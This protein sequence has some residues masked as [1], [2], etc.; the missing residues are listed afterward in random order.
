MARP[1][2]IPELYT[3]EK[4]WDEWIDHFDSVAQ[5]CGWDG[6]N[7]LKW[8]RVRLT[9][10]AGT[11]FRRLPEETRADFDRATEALRRQ[12]EPESKKELYRA[13]LQ[14]RKKKRNEEWAIFGE[15]LKNLA[16][17][18]YPA[19]PLEARERFALNQY[20]SQLDNPQVAFSVKQTKPKTVDD[21]VTYVQHFRSYLLG[22]EFQLRTDHGSLTWLANF[23]EPEG[24]L[25]RWLEQLQEFHF[26]IVHRPGK[27]HLNADALS[28]RPCTQCGRDSHGEDLTEPAPKP[29]AVLLERPPQDLRKLQLEYGPCH[30]LLQAV[31]KGKKP[32]VGDVR[33]EGPEAQRLLQL[34]E[35]L[36]VDQGLLKR[37]YEDA[38]GNSSWQQLVV[39]RTLREEIMQELHAGPLEGHLGVD[40]TVAKIKE[41]FYWPGMYRD[42]EQWIRTC[43]SCATRKSA[44]QQN[45]GPLQTIKTGYRISSIRRRGYY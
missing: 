30:L 6:A 2:V 37:K 9:E 18:A 21:A 22:R 5:V 35:R 11:F 31:E 38:R 25:A 32:D 39:P 26:Q 42:V 15:D 20:L 44:P 4:S 8:L 28:R 23:R 14:A 41:R 13:E 40:K 16:D 17:K 43:A 34:W 24:Q 12:F 33:R 3:G 45:R 10:R 29:V 27:K 19:L 7:K 36:S 1:P